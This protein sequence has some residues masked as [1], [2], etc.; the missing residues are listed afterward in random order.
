MFISIEKKQVSFTCFWIF[1]DH[2]SIYIS[3]TW[4]TCHIQVS[5]QCGKFISFYFLL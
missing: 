1:F 4:V 5:V 2:E 3:K